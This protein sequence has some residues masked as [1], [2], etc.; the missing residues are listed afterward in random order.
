MAP[1]WPYPRWIAH[2][3]AGKLAPENTLGR[4]SRRR[5]PRLPGVRVRRQAVGR[6]RAL[7]AARRDA[8]AHDLGPRPRRGAAPGPSCRASTPAAGTAARYAGEPLA[9]LRRRSP[10]FCLR[11]DF[12]LE[13]RDQAV[14]RAAS[15]RPARVVAAMAARLLGAAAGAAAAQLVPAGRAGR[16][17][18]ERRRRCRARL[19]LDTLR[20]G[21]LDEAQRA[22]LRRR[23]H[24]LRADRCRGARARS[25]APAC[26]ALVYTVN[27]PAEAQRLDALGIDGIVTDAVDRF[28][29]GAGVAD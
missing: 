17:A 9:E 23:R 24:E 6:R 16:R 12:A 26:A 7:P 8:A 19:L 4:V 21:W 18:R 10:R 13:H 14:A 29:P 20:A 25:T 5:P 27:D 22:R 2:R 3:G 28:S 15:A 1:P 11:N